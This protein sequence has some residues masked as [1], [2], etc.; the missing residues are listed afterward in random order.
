MVLP[1]LFYKFCQH[2]WVVDIVFF[3][4]LGGPSL[5]NVLKG[6]F[7]FYLILLMLEVIFFKFINSFHLFWIFFA[8]NLSFHIVSGILL[9]YLNYLCQFTICCQEIIFL[10]VIVIIICS[11]MYLILKVISIAIKLNLSM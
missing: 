3:I 9:F 1:E 2:G 11:P 10:C 5:W 4:S 8:P 7:T 6:S